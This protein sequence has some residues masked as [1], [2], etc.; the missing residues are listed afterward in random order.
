VQ[1]ALITDVPFSGNYLTHNVAFQGKPVAVGTEPE[2]QSLSVMG[3]YFRTMQIPLR[4]GRE[5]TVDDRE[6]HPLVAVVNEQFARQFF[7]DGNVLGAQIDWA[8]RAGPHKWMT[9]VGVV[10]DVK[11]S[12]LNQ[13]V[14]PAI[15]AP[16]AQSDEAWRRWTTLVVRTQQPTAGMVDAVKKQVWSLDHQIPVSE[17]ESMEE[18]MAQSVAQQRF[19]VLL[20]GAF[21]SLALLLAGVGIY[22][23]MAYRV[24]QRTH[25]I[26]VYVALGAQRADI[27]RI[28]M[29]DAAVLAG[30]GI[31]VGIAGAAAVTRLM[32]SLL[33]E[34]TPTDPAVFSAVVLV[35]GGVALLACYIPARRALSVPPTVALRCE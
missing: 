21:A 15:Y 35:L 9:I 3:D 29:R 31:C 13:P 12:G 8:R 23:I 16:F 10:G 6:D 20:L 22:G 1:A 28:I 34:V 17:I 33:F 18:L 24:T 11:H 7:P 2:V 4:S 25:E 32:T 30:I 27:L 14:D 26:G 5:L 19:N